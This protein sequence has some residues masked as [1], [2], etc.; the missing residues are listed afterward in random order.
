M[1]SGLRP[2]SVRRS[3]GPN[4]SRS[5]G[6]HRSLA[7]RFDRCDER[8]HTSWR[9]NGGR[10]SGVPGQPPGLDLRPSGRGPDLRAGSADRRGPSTECVHSRTEHSDMSTFLTEVQE[11]LV[12]GRTAR[13]GPLPPLLI[14][15]TVVTGLV[16]AFS[17]LVLGHVFVA[18]MT[19]NVVF[20]GF[21]V[22]GAHGFSIAASLVALVSFGF[23][24]VIGGRIVARY[25]HHRGR[26]LASAMVVEAIFLAA[27]VV[28]ALWSSNAPQHGFRYAL[29]VVLSLATGVQNASI[30]KLAVPDL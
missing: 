17:Y 3:V 19:G 14:A 12:P 8:R 29:I 13:F 27:A 2:R 10:R 16:D 20:L 25:G 21:A 5:T 23:G 7:D 30:R 15:M 18:N 4:G 28:L 6:C 24:S 11:T 26:H 22:A 9:A 1:V